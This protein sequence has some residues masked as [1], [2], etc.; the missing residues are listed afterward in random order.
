MSLKTAMHILQGWVFSGDKPALGVLI[1]DTPSADT[2][3]SEGIS[4]FSTPGKEPEN[5]EVM[6]KFMLTL[7]GGVR[8]SHFYIWQVKERVHR[9]VFTK[10]IWGQIEKQLLSPS[11]GHKDWMWPKAIGIFHNSLLCQWLLPGPHLLV[12]CDSVQKR[13]S[14]PPKIWLQTSL[15]HSRNIEGFVM[16]R[17]QTV[18]VGTMGK[19]V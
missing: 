12:T 4:S 7:L 1:C 11:T 13:M 5:K 17:T 2:L 14:R 8:P 9:I 18:S 6:V 15:W 3:C 16:L 10:W 19:A